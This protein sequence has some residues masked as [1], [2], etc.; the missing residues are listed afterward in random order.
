MAKDSPI[1]RDPVTQ[2]SLLPHFTVWA[3]LL[4][5]TMVWATVDECVTRRPWRAYQAQFKTLL[6]DARQRAHAD[7]INQFEEIK[8]SEGYNG[9][10]AAYEKAAKVYKGICD[11][12]EATP[13][14]PSKCEELRTG[15][16]KAK[17]DELGVLRSV[18]VVRAK[19][20]AL[21]YQYEANAHSGNE[22]DTALVDEIDRLG[23]IVEKANVDRNKLVAK[24]KSLKAELSAIET[25]HRK[26][27][28]ALSKFKQKLNIA[29]SA[30]TSTDDFSIE[31]RQLVKLEDWMV[32]RCTSC[33]LGAAYPEIRHL[34]GSGNPEYTQPFLAHSRPELLEAHPIAEFGCS[35]CHSGAGPLANDVDRAHGN[36]HKTPWPM[37]PKG[38]E[39]AG[40]VD[41]HRSQIELDHSTTFIEGKT[42]FHKL[43]C[44]GCHKYKGFAAWEDE[45]QANAGSISKAEAAYGK[46]ENKILRADEAGLSAATIDGLTLELA[47]AQTKVDSLTKRQLEITSESKRVGPNLREL[48]KKVKAEWL[49]NWIANP[50]HFRPDTN[51]PNFYLDQ[52]PDEVKAISAYLWQNSNAPTEGGTVAKISAARTPELEE[53]GRQLLL[54][55]GCTGCHRISDDI[56]NDGIESPDEIFGHKSFAADLSWI[57]DKANREYIASWIENPRAHNPVTVM[58]SLRLDRSEAVA[59]ATYLTSA[60]RSRA[61]FQESYPKDVSYLDD[62]ALAATGKKLTR[63]YGCTGCHE[64]KGLESEGRIGV[65]LT[66]EGSK[67]ISLLDFGHLTYD[68]KQEHRETKWDWFKEKL[69][70]P[71]IFDAHKMT[72]IL[73]MPN[74]RLNEREI[75]ALA[76]FMLG[77]IDKP[78]RPGVKD[79]PE[80]FRADI[81][82]GWWLVKQ[83]NCVG[84]HQIDGRG[85][86]IREMPWYAGS[87]G[88]FAPPVLDGEGSRVQ[89]DWLADF[90]RTPYTLRPHVKAKMP[91]FYLTDT[92]ATK[93]ARFF[94]SLEGHPT[95]YVAPAEELLSASEYTVAQDVITNLQCFKCHISNDTDIS[96]MDE[97]TLSSLAPNLTLTSSR[98]KPSWVERWLWNPASLMPGTKM[99][100]FYD[101]TAAESPEEEA[102]AQ[103]DFRDGIGG[104]NLTVDEA[105]KLM[106]RF[107]YQM[108]D[109]QA[110][111]TAKKLDAPKATDASIETA[112]ATEMV[113]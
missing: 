38:M 64:I 33:H 60:K 42:L 91:T 76:T 26:A 90:L 29:A 95:P 61:D 63:Y 32:D 2:K 5:V 75:N 21:V 4:A 62:P 54:E 34:E 35:Y 108:T 31:I 67:D 20:Q 41:C 14:T 110:G 80:G 99:P 57:G 111:D 8:K 74:F 85:G 68:F 36:Y 94:S 52:K 46:L 47:T 7:Q 45:A 39:E 44:W 73:R 83:F 109:D 16:S 17:T 49:P 103:A 69:R 51:M 92:E 112:P 37:H 48:K 13:D 65:E 104:H 15:I 71:R 97:D 66:Y 10:V 43:G 3:I 77:S 55:K 82:E 24:Q 6:Q 81:A 93:I 58:P 22:P 11:R 106:I 40:C 86:D 50:Q 113:D 27:K 87:R 98:L 96:A 101:P 105:Y 23:K 79:V 53:T 84:C 107:L 100:Q 28:S 12:N 89:P 9:A 19:H 18:K 25:P 30:A 78:K 88:V 102:E 72:P 56:N 70:N 1:P 59:I